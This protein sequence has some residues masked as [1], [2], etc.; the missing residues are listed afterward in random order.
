MKY[1]C[2]FMQYS[3][4]QEKYQQFEIKDFSYQNEWECIIQIHKYLM[5]DDKIR[6]PQEDLIFLKQKLEYI[7]KYFNQNPFSEETL[8][9]LIYLMGIICLYQPFYD[10]NYRTV[11]LYLKFCLIRKNIIFNYNFSDNP[12]EYKDFIPLF[13]STE[14]C[15]KESTKQK[16]LHYCDFIKDI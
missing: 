16:L 9:K 10:G 2:E 3:E 8:E 14:D 4:F 12:N 15:V 13:Y 5:K 1:G 11:F 7:I 6:C